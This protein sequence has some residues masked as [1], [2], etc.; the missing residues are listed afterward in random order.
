VKARLSLVFRA[1]F[2]LAS[3]MALVGVAHADPRVR[4]GLSAFSHSRYV[5]AA[6]LL[7][8][9]AHEG[10]AVAETYLG[11]M[12]QKGLGVAKDF[13]QAGRWYQAA[14]YQGEPTAQFFLAQLYD[15]GFGV[16]PTRNKDYWSRMRDAVAYKLSRDE[17][18]KA[19]AQ[20]T[21][22]TKTFDP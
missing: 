11:Y 19:Q 18:A 7:T 20:A 6:N 16:A 1:A 4:A 9:P 22:F 8:P 5:Q 12:C 15:L 2:G 14:A 3:A 10:D 17:L 13:G 21:A